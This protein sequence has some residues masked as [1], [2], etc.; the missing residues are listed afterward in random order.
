MNSRRPTARALCALAL[1]AACAAAQAPSNNSCSSP[2][3]VSVG[4][5]PQAPNG[6]SG[7]F[8]TN[9][10]ATNSS[11]TAFGLE[12]ATTNFNKDVWFE[13]TPTITGAHT[14]KTCTPSGFVAGTLTTSVV[15]I[16]DASVCPSG[17]TAL[18]CNDDSSACGVNSDRSSFS[19]NLWDGF[20][21]LIRVGSESVTAS[22]TFYLTIDAPATAANDSCSGAIDLTM[23]TTF[24]TFNGSNS[25]TFSY[26]CS[27][28][29]NP[30]TDV[31]FKY[32]S[33]FA[34]LLEGVEI[35]VFGAGGLV[36]YTAVYLNTCPSLFGSYTLVDCGHQ[37]VTWKPT[38]VGTYYVRVG[39]DPAPEPNLGFTMAV[40]RTSVPN[41]DDCAGAYLTYGGT[42]PLYDAQ[43]GFYTNE[44]ALDSDF[45]AVGSP[46]CPT[47]SN[48]DVWYD[49]VAT[50][51]GKVK[52]STQ[53]PPG[54]TP[55]TLENATIA[56][57]SACPSGAP[58]TLLACDD[59]PGSPLFSELT[60]DAVQGTH[61]KVMVAGWGGDSH[62]EGTF[63]LTIAPQFRLAMSAPGGPGTI[64]INVDDG[65]PNHAFFTCLTINQGAYPYGPFFGIDPTFFEIVIQL[66]SNAEPFIGFLNGA[67][68]YQ[69]G[70]APSIAGLTLYGVTL[71][72]DAVAN[73]AGV[74]TWTN[75]TVP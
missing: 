73:I 10:G 31:W 6:T 8:F 1:V 16:Y 48:S 54:Q 51:S 71:Q 29:S 59:D 43:A 66:T 28:F 9:A 19:V 57:F 52:V 61:Y 30:H 24:G 25:G 11:T 70:P 44:G 38:V 14:I 60:F 3:T 27:E 45:S 39:R 15:A 5:N 20:T 47:Y 21:Y 46:F 17:G 56:V 36:D 72:F 13:F 12:C 26:G 74:T 41:N 7:Q 34:D 65:G 4:V 49:Y 2:L 58:A 55:G 40:S 33:T 50:V 64:Q 32:E 75:F 68:D 37:I 67:G 22:G 53:T 69:F 42:Y 63:W 18:D 35:V 62:M 23:G